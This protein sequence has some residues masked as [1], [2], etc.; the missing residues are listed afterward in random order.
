MGILRIIKAFGETP[1]FISRIGPRQTT[2]GWWIPLYVDTRRVFTSPK[3]LKIIRDEIVK[4]IRKER[5]EFGIVVGGATAGI[6]P[7]VLV[8]VKL[9]KPFCYV[10]REKKKGG[11]GFAMEG[12]FK[13]GQTALLIDDAYANGTSKKAFIRN[14]R[15]AGLKIENVIVTAKRG[16]PGDERWQK[17]MKAKAYTLCTLDEIMDYMLKKKIITQECWQLMRWYTQYPDTWQK[18]PK[19]MKFLKEYKKKK[20]RKS[21]SGF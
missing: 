19:K 7:A 21:K 17:Q 9:N 6:A 4:L 12:N 8:A 10:R 13:K 3:D 5:L 20:R 2:G 16:A 14:I 15:E 18:D 11:A 1:N